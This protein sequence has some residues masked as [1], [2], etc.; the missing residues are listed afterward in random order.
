MNPSSPSS[1]SPDPIPLTYAAAVANLIYTAIASLDG[2]IEDQGGKFDWARPD[3]E[4]HA[5]VNDLMRGVGTYHYGRRM[6][7][8]MAVWETDES[9]A[10]SSEI[11]A[12]FAGIWHGADKIVYSTTLESV[13]TKRTRLERSFDPAAVRELKARA[14]RDVVIGG[15]TLAAE[16]FR[17]GL[18]DE[19]LLFLAPCLVGGGTRALPENVRRELE[20]LEER[21]FSDGMVFL[22]YRSLS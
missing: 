12:D 11:A 17:A 20:L 4:V 18:V 19:V 21:R 2:Y 7:E 9:L 10:T 16:A 15:P 22:R 6:Y 14:E 1:A 5:Y 13:W 8:T 3:E